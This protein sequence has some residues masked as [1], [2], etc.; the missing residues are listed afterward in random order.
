[1]STLTLAIL[2]ALVG[3]GLGT[4]GV[5]VAWLMRRQQR[6]VEALVRE[7]QQL[8]GSQDAMISGA[9]GMDRRVGRVEQGIQEL[10][11]QL[12]Y[13]EDTQRTA[14]P[15]DEA[16]RLV[17]QGA[18]GQRLMDELGLS[19]SEADLLIMLHGAPESGAGH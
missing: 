9:A 10:Q 1:M 12:D 14:R 17:R 3:I 8:R 6:Q 18:T 16:I 7:L 13:L 5:V 19:R 2:F 4:P 15:Y 11:K